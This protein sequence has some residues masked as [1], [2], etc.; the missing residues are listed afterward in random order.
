MIDENSVVS[1]TADHVACDMKGELLI[2]Q[3]SSAMY[4]GLDP[5]GARIW[6]LIQEPTSVRAIRDTLLREYDVDRATCTGNLMDLL[7][8]LSVKGLIEVK[9]VQAVA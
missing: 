9:P 4:Y 3:T 5:V 7:G 6:S 2:L 8:K 1:V